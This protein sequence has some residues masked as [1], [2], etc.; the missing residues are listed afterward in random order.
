M[1]GTKLDLTEQEFWVAVIYLLSEIRDVLTHG[2]QAAETDEGL[3]CQHPEEKRVSL[4]TCAE[5]DHWICSV[6]TCRYE[7]HGVVHN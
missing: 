7:H 6:P 5:P 2:V 3:G 4:A 1:D